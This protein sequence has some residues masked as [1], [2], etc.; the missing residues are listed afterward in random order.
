MVHGANPPNERKT[1]HGGG[2]KIFG[3]L[4]FVSGTKISRPKIFLIY[5][6]TAE[7]T[8]PTAKFSS[9]TVCIQNGRRFHG[10]KNSGT[11][12][13]AVEHATVALLGR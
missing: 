7:R 4:I 6:V 2:L 3:R 10:H 1:T 9:V 12:D 13:M 8:S 11:T 5:S